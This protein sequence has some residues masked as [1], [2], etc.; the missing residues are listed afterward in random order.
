MAVKKVTLLDVSKHTG[1]SAGTISEILN[2]KPS[3]YNEETKNRIKAAAE[4][5]EYRPNFTARSLRTQKTMTVGLVIP[6][7]FMELDEIEE[8]C[9]SNGYSLSLAV[10]HNRLERQDKKLFE[11]KQRQVDGL[12][13]VTPLHESS[14]ISQ[15][16]AEKYP[17]VICDVAQNY[18]EIDT[19]MI[20]LKGSICLAFDQLRAKGHRNIAVFSWHTEAP[21]SKIR[22]EAFKNEWNKM[23]IKSEDQIYFP[24]KQLAYATS[25]SVYN[26]SYAAG[27][28]FAA[29]FA[30]NDPKRPTAIVAATD[31]IAM[32][33]IKALT[34]AGWKIPE[35]I[36]MVSTETEDVGRFLVNPI[37]SVNVFHEQY[38]LEA[39]KHLIYKLGD[40]KSKD[41][42][43]IKRM[44]GISAVEGKTI[45]AP[46][47]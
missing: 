39:F 44:F 46:C 47:F 33:A 43:V 27:K 42:P 11:L 12:L 38:R 16:G 23:G 2:N 31:R 26:T 37:N 21:Y 45:A 9:S 19:F 24:L 10:T 14:V 13:I 22:F 4:K 6:M 15:L 25:G 32:G 17:I 3:R 18:P 29:R 30:K 40:K 7:L 41:A 36:S 35:D 5:L 8:V 20:D 34:E 1:Y 28:E